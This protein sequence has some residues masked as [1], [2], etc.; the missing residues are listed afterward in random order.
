MTTDLPVGTPVSGR[1]HAG[2]PGS[3]PLSAGSVTLRP[4]EAAADAGAL[5][6]ASHGD[7][8]TEALW[9]YM[10]YGPFADAA[11]MRTW[12]EDCAASTDPV[13]R[14]VL[15]DRDR[16]CGMARYLS[17]HNFRVPILAFTSSPIVARRMS[18][19]GGVTPVHCDP[20]GDGL[21]ATWTDTV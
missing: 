17:Q 19:L 10:P 13:F 21:L 20:P 7:P 6:A 15:D 4:L 16:P 12:L 8:T 2:R 11:S 14:T 3:E 9:T 18:V 5:Y 1:D